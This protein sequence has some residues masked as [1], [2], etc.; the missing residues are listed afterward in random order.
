M[1]I[2]LSRVS[3]ELMNS[4]VC[5]GHLGIEVKINN[6]MYLYFQET[7]NDEVYVYS[8]M[9]MRGGPSFTSCSMSFP[10]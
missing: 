6:V 2:R 1:V 10:Q 3:N 9:P 8:T 4:E 5:N 7:A